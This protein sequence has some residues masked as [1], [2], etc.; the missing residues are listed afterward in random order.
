MD[1]RF[2]SFLKG[3][4]AGSLDPALVVSYARGSWNVD[5]DEAESVKLCTCCMRNRPAESRLK[6]NERLENQIVKVMT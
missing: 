4:S 3:S 2:D 6:S 1:G 5:G